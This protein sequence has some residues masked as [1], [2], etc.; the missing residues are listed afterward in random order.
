MLVLDSKRSALPR[1]L[2]GGLVAV[3]IGVGAPAPA[4]AHFVLQ[5]PAATMVQDGLGSPQKMAPC[6]DD[7][8]GTPTGMVTA[9]QAG[10]TIT[11]TVDEKIYHPGHYRISIGKNGPGDIPVEPIVT[12]G[13]STPC[14][15]APVDANPKFPVLADGVFEHKAPFNGP[16][17]ITVTL[18]PDVTC[19]HCTLQV[20][21]FMSNHPLNNPGGCYYHHCANIS[22]SGSMSSTTSGGPTSTGTGSAGETS[23]TSTSAGAGTTTTGGAGGAAGAGG[24]TSTSGSTNES[25][26][27]AVSGAG[28]SS[29][30]LTG[31]AGLFALAALARRRRQKA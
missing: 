31:V 26:G 25:S 1:L 18:P 13:P 23:A 9:Y 22:I 15:T 3:A 4:N 27:C 19:D 6:G 5:A 16:Q 29:S 30:A 20:L 28:Q 8:S 7:G 2:A 11:I 24:S 17:T 12:P 14:G 10:Q 21:E